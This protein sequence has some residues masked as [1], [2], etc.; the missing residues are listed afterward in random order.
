MSVSLWQLDESDPVEADV[1]IVGG[2][3]C[4]VSAA[5]EAER[6]GA[7][8]VLLERHSIA[9]GASGRN[10]GYLMRGM[11]ES[12]AVVAEDLGRDRAR[13]IW[14]WSEDN[15]KSLRALGAERTE[16]FAE[17]PSCL[18]ALEA[19]EAEELA[20]SHAM[21]Q[22]DGLASRLIE[23]DGSIDAVW[24]S[25]R[26]LLGLVNPADAVCQPVRLVRMLRD[27]FETTRLIESRE[28][29]SIEH[30]G[31]GV[32]LRTNGGTVRA[33]KVLV[34]T[35]AWAAE[36][37][38]ELRGVVSPKRGQM[39]AARPTGDPVRLKYAYYLNRGDEYL[40][41]GP[42]GELLMGGA[43]SSEPAAESGDQSGTHP[44]VQARLER[45]LC[46]F[47]GAG[48]EVTHRWSGV[49]GFGP[50]HLPVVGQTT[51][52]RVWVC[53]GFTGHGMSLGHLTATRIC[54]AMLG[55]GE[56]PAIFNAPVPAKSTIDPSPA[57]T[58][59]SGRSLH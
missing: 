42:N 46:E 39:L 21:L 45:W 57:V 50:G 8:A 52:D 59:S 11:A 9:S 7:S 41:S 22:E 15:L 51:N 36:L 34:C 6:L 23:P 12:Y 3:V 30:R 53:A 1:A 48:F 40:R 44:V 2:G 56:T 58:P 33:Q 31:D 5:L 16:G 43:R 38:P 28:V 4:G 10:A 29:A 14:A 24:R 13:A 17:M 25:G 18:V 32:E 26:A 27:R 49:M 35:N 55:E 20:R 19:E 37:V 54:A 47:T